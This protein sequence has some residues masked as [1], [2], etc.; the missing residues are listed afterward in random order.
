MRLNQAIAK[1]LEWATFKFGYYTKR[2]YR[3]YLIKFSK[4]LK[5]KKLRQVKIGDVVKFQSHL[6]SSRKDATVF[7]YSSCVKGFI[8]FWYLQNKIKINPDLIALPRYTKKHF[9]YLTEEEYNLLLKN[10]DIHR[11]VKYHH[12]YGTRNELIINFLYASGVRVSELCDLELDNLNLQEQSAII[13]TK[14]N[15]QYRKIFWNHI[16]NEILQ[17]YLDLRET[18]AKCN[19][20]FINKNGR[21]LTTRSVE[22]IIKAIRKKAKIQKQITPHSFRHSVGLRAV[23]RNMNV[24]LLQELLGHQNLNSSAIYMRVRNK[25]LKKEYDKIFNR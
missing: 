10:L 21:K 20:I 17:T 4:F 16:T 5:N 3:Q 18:L 12:F 13:I 8:K 14:K 2:N 6:K 25:T 19:Y 11:S 15:R 24:R 23:E 7:Y 1:Y 22:R 9:E